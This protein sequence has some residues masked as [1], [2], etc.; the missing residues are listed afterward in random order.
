LL[1]KRWRALLTAEDR[2]EALKET[3]DRKINRRYLPLFAENRKKPIEQLAA[4]APAPPIKRYAYRSFDRQWIL[5][6]N[7]LGDYLRPVFWRTY[8]DQQVFLT[9]LFSQ[10]LGVGPAL[11]AC[12]EIP[13]LD[14]FRGSYGAKA[15]IPLYR[16][17]DATA[18]NLSPGLL[19]QMGAAYGRAVTPEEFV[20][21]VYGL[22]AQP[23]FTARFFEELE[24]RELRVPLTRDP[25][26]FEA[27]RAVGARLLWLHTY[28]ARFVPPGESPGQVPPGRARCTQAVPGDP[29]G[30]PA[31]FE[32][33]ESTRTLHVGAGVFAPVE[34]AVFDFE[35]SGLKVVQSWLSYRMRG[36]AGRKS[37]PLDDIEPQ[38]WPGQF[39]T[40]LL[41][42]LWVLERTVAGY[43][44]QARLLEAVVAG[45]C[46]R[47]GELPAPP[48]PMRKAPKP[49]QKFV[50][51]L[52]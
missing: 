7:R 39:T 12:A 36:S 51:R 8:S 2:A 18:A 6:D 28:G 47:A 43:P 34:P 50:D 49:G 27:V 38:R 44:E 35:V 5:A 40:E 37:S 17:A 52:L 46:F 30:Y 1:R 48:E 31:S 11:T 25:A 26:L 4:D 29:A 32:Y 41:E 42:L 33:H 20:A 16:T 14:H 22:L 19:D 10:P 21:Y 15:A 3:R 45:A 24:T 9:G 13:D 23:A